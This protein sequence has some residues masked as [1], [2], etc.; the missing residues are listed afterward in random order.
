[1]IKR[2]SIEIRYSY[3]Y[4]YAG[5][6][7]NVL[8]NTMDYCR[9]ID[10]FYGEPMNLFFYKPYQKFSI[11][12]EFI[13][14]IVDRLFYEELYRIDFQNKSNEY[15][16]VKDVHPYADLIRELPINGALREYG[17]VHIGFLQWLSDYG[18]SYDKV[19][20]DIANDYYSY[21]QESGLYYGLLDRLVS[22]VFFLLFSNRKILLDFNSL[23]AE[24]ISTER[25][26]EMAGDK[27]VNFSSDG[28]LKRVYIPRWV[29]RAV[30]F[31][32]RGRCVLCN[33]DL[34]NLVS[35]NNKEYF[36]HMVPLVKGGTN[37]VTNMQLLC[38]RCNTKK[39][40]KISSTS[41]FYEAWY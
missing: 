40:G 16:R 26:D 5:V 3:T 36:D 17:M 34:T 25:I 24:V 1:M 33:K 39:S 19:E 22:E 37:D 35:L 23:I 38:H 27:K 30:F 31:R 9:A 28:R 20:I 4:Y 8:E 21:L 15:N 14:F 13:E 7:K 2:Q 6:I 41:M 18:I 29:K 32:D 11:L 12:H 10:E